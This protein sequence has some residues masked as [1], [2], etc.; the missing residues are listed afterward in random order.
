M[1]LEGLR[2]KRLRIERVEATG[3][4]LPRS[5]GGDDDRDFRIGRHGRAAGEYRFGP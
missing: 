4:G 1:D 3:E 5:V 2:G